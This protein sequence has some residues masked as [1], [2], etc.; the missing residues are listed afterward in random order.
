MGNCVPI[1]LSGFLCSGTTCCAGW[2]RAP[3]DG[4]RRHNGRS[5]LHRHP[6]ALHFT[7]AVK[8][9]IATTGKDWNDPSGFQTLYRL[10]SGT[11]FLPAFG[12]VIEIVRHTDHTVG[13]VRIELPSKSAGKSQ[14]TQKHRGN[15]AYGKK[16]NHWTVKNCR[17]CDMFNFWQAPSHRDKHVPVLSKLP[18]C[19]FSYTFC[20]FNRLS[21]RFVQLTLNTCT[22]SQNDSVSF[23]IA[24]IAQ[25]RG[26]TRRFCTTPPCVRVIGLQEIEVNTSF[27]EKK[28]YKIYWFGLKNE[29]IR[30][31]P[32]SAQPSV[33]SHFLSVLVIQAL[34]VVML[35]IS[36]GL[37]ACSCGY[38]H[39]RH[40]PAGP[41]CD[42]E[43]TPL[44]RHCFFMTVSF[45][46]SVL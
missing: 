6:T 11:S 4:F 45:P 10:H 25:Y 21:P 38:L 46:L 27:D 29:Q 16:I 5:A 13:Y 19:L 28:H 35:V 24:I 30:L 15:L 18:V 36:S 32:S 39:E 22:C 42:G 41:W 2:C 3:V 44:T 1:F 7:Q 12:N 14:K 26:C 31:I 37:S 43:E 34:C 33:F 9:P 40:C 17:I 20:R 8:H 23:F